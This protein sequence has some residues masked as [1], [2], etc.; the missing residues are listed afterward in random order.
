[1]K[2]EDLLENLKKLTQAG[3]ADHKLSKDGQGGVTDCPDLS[4]DY[5]KTELHIPYETKCILTKKVLEKLGHKFSRSVDQTIFKE[6]D[7]IIINLEPLFIDLRSV[8]HLAKLAYSIYFIRKKLSKNMTLFPFRDHF[9]IR[10]FPSLLY[11]TFG[12]KP[13]LCILTHA[14]LKDKY[15][16]F[17]EE[18]ILFT[19]QKL[20]PEIQ[21]VKDSVYAFQPFRDTVK[22]LYFEISKKSGASFTSEEI[23]R[24]KELL[25]QE[26]KFSIEQL[27]PRVFV[28]RDAEQMLKNILTLSREIRFISDLPQVMILFDQQSTQEAIFNIILVKI[29]KPDQPLLQEWFA[30]M[31][32][33]IECR[34]EYS[35]VV[36]YLRK[37]YP[38]EAKV[39]RIKLMKDLSLLR[40]D[41]SLHFYLARQRVSRLIEDAIGEFR[42]YNGGIIIKQWETLASLKEMFCEISSKEPDLLENFYYSLSPVEAQATLSLESLRILFALFLEAQNSN[43]TKPSDFFL[44]FLSHQRQLFI[45]IRIPDQNLKEEI[46]SIVSSLASMQNVVTFTMLAQNTYFLGYLLTDL[47]ID[48]QQQLSQGITEALKNWKCKIESR[49]ILQLSLRWSIVSLD[50]RIGG[51]QVSALVL[52]M[53]FEGLM[54]KNKQGELEYGI[55]QQVEI[56]PDQK[57]Y[58]FQLRSTLWSDGSQLSAHD[59]EY[60][61]KKVLSP[62]FKTPFAYLFYPIKNAKLAKKG[63]LP[64]DKIG[65][66]ALNNRTLKVELEFPSPYFLELTAHTIYSPVNRLVDQKHPNWPFEDKEAYLC[67]GAF[68]LKKNGLDEEYQLIRNPL[69]W[70]AA[71]IK[72]D[73]IIV[74]QVDPYQSYERFQKDLNHWVGAPL[75]TWNPTFTPGEADETIIFSDTSIFWFVFNTQCFPFHHKKIRQALS[76]SINL[77][78]LMDVLK[79]QPTISPLHPIHSQMKNAPLYSL[80][81]AQTLFN[82]GLEELGLSLGDF[83][84]ISLIYSNGSVRN[85]AVHFLKEEWE[86]NFGIRC[87]VQPLEWEIL[88]AKIT[89][90]NFQVGGIIWESW[91]SDP[92]YTLNAFRDDRELINFPKWKNKEYQEIMHLAEREIDLQK[93]RSYYLQAETILLEEMPVLPLFLVE[94]E[95]LKKKNF[96]VHCSSLLVNFKWGYFTLREPKN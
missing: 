27:V 75:G 41:M 43:L 65:I 73:E 87:Q 50:P 38:L 70:D 67:N 28:V 93:R 68:Q 59:F 10:I 72:L 17:D 19:I 76:W 25:K 20:M 83:P 91:I 29:R 26:M 64:P 71:N 31:H 15:Q 86:E 56:S 45:L 82:E 96:H 1:M 49:Q 16:I 80:K 35:Q 54:R 12:T 33:D 14:H 69:Y 13:V 4:K 47:K 2:S 62:I 23:K 7:R 24:L 9:D 95:A 94:R 58:L 89:E 37:K 21:L 63:D 57:T 74:S 81:K 79:K 36:R 34:L 42:D 92:I 6:L 8:D 40:V 66:K 44:K 85:Q 48:I 84:E 3:L 18:K 77:A 30:R 88:F 11:F 53:L 46:Y 90:G 51:D 61:W 60:A 5:E 39:F 22:T 55:A 78:R 52:M 32:P